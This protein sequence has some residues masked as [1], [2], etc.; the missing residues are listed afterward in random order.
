MVKIA[1]AHKDGD[2]NYFVAHQYALDAAFLSCLCTSTKTALFC[3]KKKP[4][5]KQMNNWLI[6]VISTL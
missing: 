5:K 2:N 4:W 1:E 3:Q 6:F